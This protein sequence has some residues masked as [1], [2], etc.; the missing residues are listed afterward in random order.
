MRCGRWAA[1][2]EGDEGLALLERA[3]ERLDH[4]QAA[5]ERARA[6]VDYGAALRR[7]RK[8]RAAR[9][10]LHRG[11]DL[12]LSLRR[13]AASSTGRETSSRA[14]GARPRRTAVQGVESLTAREQQVAALASGGLLNREIAHALYVTVKTV[15]W[16]LKHAYKK[17]DVSSRTEL[18]AR[19][20]APSSESPREV[21]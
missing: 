14:A 3:V 13:Q 5:L 7:R 1:S 11:L 10:P 20:R 21:P 18:R 16:H 15:E 6:L 17:L 9:E 12:A 4:S 2:P 8:R 19:S